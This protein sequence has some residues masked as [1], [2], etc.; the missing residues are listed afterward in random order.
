MNRVLGS[1]HLILGL[2]FAWGITPVDVS[3]FFK[4]WGDSPG[5]NE[6]TDV[7]PEGPIVGRVLSSG[8]KPLAVFH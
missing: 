1:A 8:M 3:S 6:K 2:P 7:Q 5:E 4:V